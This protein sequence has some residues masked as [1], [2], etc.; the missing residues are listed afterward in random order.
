ML[1]NSCDLACYKI[2]N[3]VI[4]LFW[5]T[6]ILI[7]ILFIWILLIYYNIKQK[8]LIYSLTLSLLLIS[9]IWILSIDINY[10][11][12]LTTCGRDNWSYIIWKLWK[13]KK[14]RKI[15]KLK[16]NP[17]F[18]KSNEFYNYLDKIF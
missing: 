11:S 5:P 15:F 7:F 4:N 16:I 2:L 8:I 12:C 10:S 9:I 6:L 3:I 13:N 14:E 1:Y 17:K 18:N